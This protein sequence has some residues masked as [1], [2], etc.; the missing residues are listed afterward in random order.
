M[1]AAKLFLSMHV[2]VIIIK[3]ATSKVLYLCLSA[4]LMRLSRLSEINIQLK[5]PLLL[6]AREEPAMTATIW[7]NFFLSTGM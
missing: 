3:T 1:T 4:G 6:I 2:R 5:A 7:L